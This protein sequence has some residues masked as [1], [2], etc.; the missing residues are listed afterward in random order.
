MKSFAVIGIGRMGGIHAENLV[1]GRVKF[2]RL[3]A[4]CDLDELKLDKFTAKHKGV[5]AFTDYKEMISLVKP[6]AVIIAT[7]HYSH[8]EIAIY[9]LENGV[10]V[11]SE[12]PQAVTVGECMRAN[13]VAEAR[14]NALYG[15]MFNQRTNRVYAKAKEIV[16]SGGIGE[17]RRVTFIVTDWYRS[18]FYYDMGEWRASWKGEGGGILI[19]QCVHQLDVMQWICGMPVK[20]D[21]T[22]RTVNRDIT[23]ENDVTAVLEYKNG[24][25]GTFIASGHELHGTNRLEIAGDKG[26]LVIGKYSL[27][28]VSFDR[29]EPEVNA[30]V[31]KGYGSVKA[32]TKRYYYGLF[33][34]ITDLVYGQQ[35]R[36]VRAFAETLEG[37]RK[38]PVAFGEEGINALSIIN[39]IYLS[40]YKNKTAELPLDPI[41]TEEL[42]AELRSREE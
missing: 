40:A 6:D 33:R 39:G 38:T 30:S 13:A 3:T 24:A 14:P 5:L 7:P 42:Y 25:M 34:L 8:V 1:R 26:K 23:V 17:I 22:A 18:Q 32:H 31:T 29:S 27:K 20:I 35:I 2:A 11:L 36:V 41:E 28:Y 12:K 16:A 4:V 37:R 9:C 21:A 10:N 19:N 15:I